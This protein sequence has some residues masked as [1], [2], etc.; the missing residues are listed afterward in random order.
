MFA[1]EEMLEEK[2]I[3]MKTFLAPPDQVNLYLFVNRWM[4]VMLNRVRNSTSWSDALVIAALEVVFIPSP[5]MAFIIIGR[6]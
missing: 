3:K 2:L 6:I 1:E 5:L 4:V